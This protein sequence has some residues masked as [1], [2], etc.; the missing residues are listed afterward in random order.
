MK[1]DISNLK[2]KEMKLLFRFFK[3]L[4]YEYHIKGK[5][6]GSTEFRFDTQKGGY[7]QNI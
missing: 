2:A 6:D 4:G 7:I 3:A 1:I 5:G